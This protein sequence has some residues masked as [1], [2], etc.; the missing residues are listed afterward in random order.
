MRKL[1]TP[2][3]LL[4]AGAVALGAPMA[5]TAAAKKKTTITLS[6]S[7]SVYPLASLLI[8][9]YLKGP[10]K[11]KVAFRM[12]QG[13]SDVGVSD[14][15]RGRVTIGNSSRDPKSSDPQ[16]ITFNKI[17]KDAL[18]L[19]VNQQNTTTN[20]T[21]AQVQAIFSGKVRDWADVPGSGRTGTINLVVRT[22]ASGSQDAFQKIFLGSATLSSAATAEASSGLV[23]TKVQNDAN[24]IGYVSLDFASKLKTVGYNG[25]ACNLQNAKTG[26][27]GGVRNFWMVTR[28]A[29]TGETKKFLKWIQTNAKARQIISTEWVPIS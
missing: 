29:P 14:V 22:A 19:V 4:T 18:C 21:Q 7:T 20:L 28:G 15:A 8:K 10:G 2:V 12:A 26:E 5:A 1:T 24:A 9:E 17:A 25:V 13:G 3:A 11:N 16:G 27:Y 23:A 6:G